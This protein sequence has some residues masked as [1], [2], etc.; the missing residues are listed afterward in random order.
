MTDVIQPGIDQVQQQWLESQAI[1][2][3]LHVGCG[4]KPIPWAV[5]IDPNESRAR[6]RDH[7]YDV[8]DLP[9]PDETFDSVVSS[10]VLPSLQRIHVAMSEMIRVL[11]IGGMWAHVIPDWRYAPK[12]KDERFVWQYQHQ[13]WNGPDEFAPFIARYPQLEV[14]ELCSFED[15][16]WAFRVIA[17]RIR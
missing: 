15:F 3:C 4:E 2:E 13:G 1:G 8:H 11:K 12:R 17:R 10:H 7:D 16:N 6:W 14:V 5:N 9:Y